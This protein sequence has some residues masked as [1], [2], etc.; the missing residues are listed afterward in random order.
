MTEID[1]RRRAKDS[2]KTSCP[3]SNFYFRLTVCEFKNLV[4]LVGQMNRLVEENIRQAAHG[5]LTNSDN[6]VR[7]DSN[8]SVNRRTLVQELELYVGV[9]APSS[10]LAGQTMRQEHMDF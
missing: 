9:H 8:V 2:R 6:Q 4:P 5:L 1:R 7:Q 10:L 3:V